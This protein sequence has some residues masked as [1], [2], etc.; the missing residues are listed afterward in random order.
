LEWM[1]EYNIGKTTERANW[2]YGMDIQIEKKLIKKY[3]NMSKNKI[4]IDENL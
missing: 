3:V 2:F 4:T 1:R